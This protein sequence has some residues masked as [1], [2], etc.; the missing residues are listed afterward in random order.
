MDA[1]P[2]REG[3]PGDNFAIAVDVDDEVVAGEIFSKLGDGGTVPMPFE[4]T[5]STWRRRR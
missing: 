1:P 3:T 2:G 4:A 5:F